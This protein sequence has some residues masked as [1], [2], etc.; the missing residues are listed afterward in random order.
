MTE[1]ELTT[2]FRKQ[3]TKGKMSVESCAIIEDDETGKPVLLVYGN[4]DKMCKGDF[5]TCVHMNAYDI[6]IFTK[7]YAISLL[8]FLDCG[9]HI[10]GDVLDN[11]KVDVCDDVLYI[12]GTGRPLEITDSYIE[13]PDDIYIDNI[14]GIHFSGTELDSTYIHISYIRERKPDFITVSGKN[15]LK[16]SDI[17]NDDDD[18][19]I[20]IEKDDVDVDWFSDAE[21][22]YGNTDVKDVIERANKEL[23][24]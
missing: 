21:P 14:S 10:Y 20:T 15:D 12:H 24:V 1:Q 13:S 9:L 8:R 6:K 5:S 4:L 16:F 19:E 3:L 17:I 23:F 11:V 18:T 7:E 2:L 22:L